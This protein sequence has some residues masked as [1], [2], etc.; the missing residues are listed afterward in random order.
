[1][2]KILFGD[3]LSDH[4]EAKKGEARTSRDVLNKVIPNVDDKLISGKDLSH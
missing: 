2:A 4:D 1:V 3:L